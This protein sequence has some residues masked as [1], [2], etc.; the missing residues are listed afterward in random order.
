MVIAYQ[1]HGGTYWCA[2]C[3]EEVYEAE[4][5]RCEKEDEELD[6]YLITEQG[7]DQDA[8]LGC[9]VECDEC[10][11]KWSRCSE[12]WEAASMD[13]DQVFTFA[14]LDQYLDEPRRLVPELVTDFF[15]NTELDKALYMNHDSQMRMADVAGIENFSGDLGQRIR[16]AADAGLRER[17]GTWIGD[18]LKTDLKPGPM[19]SDP[20]E[21]EEAMFISGGNLLI[22]VGDNGVQRWVRVWPTKQNY[23]IS[24][25]QLQPDAE[26]KHVDNLDMLK[27]AALEREYGKDSSGDR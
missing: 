13:S 12:E 7:S 4:K 14:I 9:G 11:S 21:L 2:D 19:A 16:Q 10:L 3:G 25:W 1:D 15:A 17:V 6:M 26:L 23:Q 27:I 18:R 5:R 22:G 24:P 20:P 8:Q